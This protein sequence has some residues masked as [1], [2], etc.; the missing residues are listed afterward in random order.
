MSAL[1][2]ALESA[3]PSEET[4]VQNRREI[5]E[6]IEG[7]L[8]FRLSGEDREAISAVYRA[9]FDGQLE[10]RFRSHGRPPMPYHPTYRRLLT[11]RSLSGRS[12]H[13]LSSA[14]DYRFVR[15]LVRAGR[16]VP[17]VGDF[18]GPG[19]LRA[20]GSFLRGR[21]EVVSAF[22]VS[23]V[24][25]YLIRA[26]RFEDFAD[27]VA[28]LPVSERSLFI[29]AYFDYGLPHPAELPGERSTTILQRIPRFLALHR[30]GAYRTFWDVC[31][32]D[33]LK[34]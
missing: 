21:G 1:L 5:L 25:F 28:A 24:E 20:V 9:F 2:D 30:S 10:L 29:R 13:F 4:F 11:A 27:N 26:G 17:V 23:N 32:V 14:E 7:R 15:E 8:G 18:A 3:P 16:V 33:Y 6:H 31:T 22:Y 34:P 12:G 19:A